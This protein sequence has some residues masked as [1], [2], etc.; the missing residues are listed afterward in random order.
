MKRIV[1]ALVIMAISISGFAQKSV[2]ALFSK[3]SG[4]D[5]FTSITIN[6]NLLKL[7]RAFDNDDE[8]NFWPG[9]VS[10]IR[11]LV[12]DDEGFYAANF[13]RMVERELDRKNYE[14]FMRINDS[15]N[16]V[17]MFVRSQGASFTEFLVI[18]GDDDGEDNVLIQVKGRMT[19]K[20]AR[21][22]ADK[23]KKDHGA[24]IV[25]SCR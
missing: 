17:L 11:I 3:Y 10:V 25:I 23:I 1:C 21:E 5:G 4:E 12:Q 20:E 16:D 13:F 15:D 2:D 24:E 8:D 7:I 9:D 14:E 18:A 22:F 6:G 19:H